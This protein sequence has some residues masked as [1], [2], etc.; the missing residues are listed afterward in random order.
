MSLPWFK[1]PTAD[2][3]AGMMKHRWTR[4]NPCPVY[5]AQ[6]E[7]MALHADG[8]RTTYSVRDLAGRWGWSTTRTHRWLKKQ[9]QPEAEQQRNASG[10]AAEQQRNTKPKQSRG[11]SSTNGTE[12]EP[13]ADASR[14]HA[15]LEEKEGDG[16]RENNKRE[17]PSWVPSGKPVGLTREEVHALTLQAQAQMLKDYRARKGERAGPR[18]W[19]G[20]IKGRGS[21]TRQRALALLIATEGAT[22]AMSA[23]GWY[24]SERLDKGYGGDGIDTFLEK[25][26]TYAAK[27]REKPTPKTNGQKRHA[28]HDWFGVAT[29]GHQQQQPRRRVDPDARSEEA[30]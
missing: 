19:T 6:L 8:K 14:A 10:T 27:I 23:W 30:S 2:T 11:L 12:A 9:E 20:R 13:N 24:L 5:V 16:D 22:D 18:T 26:E 1:A 3:V 25:G 21:T 7:L 15:P 29:G 17:V 4:E 28:G